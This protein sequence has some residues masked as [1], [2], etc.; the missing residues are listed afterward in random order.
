[1]NPCL[2]GPARVLFA[3]S[4]HLGEPGFELELCNKIEC[5]LPLDRSPATRFIKY[6]WPIAL[7]SPG[8]AARSGGDFSARH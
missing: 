8:A 6:N 3:G 5:V 2:K 4:M 7:L 1:M